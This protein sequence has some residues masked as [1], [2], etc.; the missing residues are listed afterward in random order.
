MSETPATDPTKGTGKFSPFAGCSIFI[1][2]GALALGMIGFTAWSYFKVKEK[3][4]GFT[5][6][7]P[8]PI[9]LVDT[10][11][12]EVQQT[13]LKAK[14]V[15]F[16][17][18]IEAKHKGEMT[19]D[20]DEMNLAIATF[21]ILKPHRENLYITAI[22]DGQIE[23]QVSY[24]VK[25]RIGSDTMRYLT[26]SV[27]IKPELVEGGAFPRV[28][29]IRPDKQGDIPDEFRKFIS[30]TLL[31]PIVNDKEL[32]PLFKSLSSVEV[33]GDELILQTDPDY[34]APTT[35][36]E[37]TRESILDRFALGFG[38]I[39][40]IFLGIVAALIIISRRKAKSS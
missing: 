20:A 10:T 29:Q 35:P 32:G 38:I 22:R 23:A 5:G 36:E 6:E 12:K 19:L 14:F 26:G 28:M 13:A 8:K 30:E 27:T 37:S 39:A 16:R 21:D 11:G 40:V 18:N 2:A 31:H 15:G 25:S 7:N 3:I 33:K 1:I 4:E 34:K 9:E 17:H 24:P